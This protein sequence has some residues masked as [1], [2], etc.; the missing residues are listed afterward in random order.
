MNAHKDNVGTSKLAP[1]SVPALRFQL[2]WVHNGYVILFYLLSIIFDGL[3][4]GT[5]IAVHVA[6]DSMTFTLCCHISLCRR[7]IKTKHITSR[8]KLSKS[9]GANASLEVVYLEAKLRLLQHAPQGP[10]QQPLLVRLYSQAS[11][12]LVPLY[13]D[14]KDQGLGSQSHVMNKLNSEKNL[15]RGIRVSADLLFMVNSTCSINL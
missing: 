10:A 12:A 14:L 11:C 2:G 3:Y 8:L 4:S 5:E 6:R 15:T 13:N 9:P 7:H 1:V